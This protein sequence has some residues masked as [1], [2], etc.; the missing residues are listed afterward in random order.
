MTIFCRI[1][2]RIYKKLNGQSQKTSFWVIIH[3]VLFLGVFLLWS[4][5]FWENYGPSP[6]VVE[7]NIVLKIMAGQMP[8]I[9]FECEY[10]PVALLLFIIPGV[11]FRALPGY[12]IAFTAEML[13]FDILAIFLIVFIAKRINLSK[14]KALT[15]YTLLI[16]IA[17]GPIVTH[18]YDLAPAI[19]VLA[20]LAAFLAGRNKTAWGVLALGVMAKIFPL[21]VAPLF[22]IW[23]LAKKQYARLFKGIAVFAGVIMMTVVPWLIIDARSL[24]SFLIYHMDR[25]LHAESTYGSFIILGQHFGWTSV[26]Y[27]FT[28]GSFN[29]TSGLADKLSD[30]SFFIMGAVFL[31][32]YTIFCS[33]L[34]R[35]ELNNGNGVNSHVEQETLLV[36]YV[37]ISV[38]AF[39]IFNKVFSAQYMAWFCPLVPLLNIRFKS[40]II[41]ML[42][43][44]GLFTMYVYPFNYIE[45]EYY[46]S[47][48]V[49]LMA[50]RNLLLITVFVLVCLGIKARN[51]NILIREANILN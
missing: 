15:S 38:L 23:L 28:F 20:A 40:L 22:A 47:L 35:K 41:A 31:L 21:V 17:A 51:G 36:R 44:A 4:H 33:K 49:L 13:L 32:V 16:A 30:A 3:V 8:Y 34:G 37:A 12:Y 14:V 9:H 27:D 10:P 11:F 42:M 2:N 48:P 45:F 50:G 29:I 46:E 25:G 26:D 18:R 7:K 5:L 39:L 43:I 1:Y 19:M 6:G 24:G